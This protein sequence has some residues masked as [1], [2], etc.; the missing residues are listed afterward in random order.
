M[1]SGPNKPIRLHLGCGSRYLNG[2]INVDLPQHQRELIQGK[3]D[4]AADFR[5]LIY[6]PASVSE[7]R[8]HHALEHFTRAGALKLLIQWR[9][10]LEIGGT[11]HIETPDFDTAC[12]YYA[13]SGKKAR[14]EI[15][16]HVFGS[17]EA[18]WANHYDGWGKRKYLFVLKKLGFTALKFEK[19]SNS[20][21]TRFNSPL[22]NWLGLLVPNALY[23][24]F[25]MNKLPNITVIAKKSERNIDERAAVADILREYLVGTEGEALLTVW[26]EQIFEK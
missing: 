17:Q 13:L 16:R 14:A 18:P 26:L 9:Q 20:I 8:T 23:R 22:F 2:Y 25:G 12:W 24:H 6:E 11:L 21:S 15:S 19:R 7:I 3:V 1:K 10:W 4:V 5:S